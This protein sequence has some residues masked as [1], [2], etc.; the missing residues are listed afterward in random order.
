MEKYLSTESKFQIVERIRSSSDV[1]KA[2][3]AEGISRATY[4]RW[5]KRVEEDGAE[6]LIPRSRTP[7]SSP[8]KTPDATV[9]RIFELAKSG[10]YRFASEIWRVLQQEGTT[11]SV[12]TVIKILRSHGLYNRGYI[13]DRNSK[14]LIPTHIF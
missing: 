6:G 13:N 10:N 12:N 3:R 14:K 9:Q 8:K 11:V 7:R 5:K 2:C 1:P 4:Y